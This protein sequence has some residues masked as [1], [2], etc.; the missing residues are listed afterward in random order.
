MQVTSKVT[1]LT[2]ITATELA[3]IGNFLSGLGAVALAI[4]AFYGVYRWGRKS[5]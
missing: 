4:V 5:H 3:A 2:A 1:D